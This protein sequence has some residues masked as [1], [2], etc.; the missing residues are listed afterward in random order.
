MKCPKCN[1]LGFETGDRCRNCGYDFSL[2]ADPGQERIESDLDL[3]DAGV[4]GTSDWLAQVDMAAPE[5]PAPASPPPAT[6]EPPLVTTAVPADVEKLPLFT[7]TLDT[8]EDDE[9]LIKVPPAPRPPLAVRRTPDTPRLRTA[10]TPIRRSE[11][12]AAPELPLT[13]P[14]EPLPAARRRAS[15]VWREPVRSTAEPIVGETGSPG[16]RAAAAALDILLLGGIDLA[17]VYFTLRMAGLPMQEWT[18]LPPVPLTAFLLLIKFSY[19]YAFTAVGGQTIGKMAA[20]IRVVSAD[21]RPLDAASALRRT[22]AGVVS[23]VL[24]G[25]GFLP[26]LVTSDRRALHD[27]M[28]RTRVITVPSA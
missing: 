26:A 25:L 24:L 3:R 17:V 2:M 7:P 6:P 10:A 21:E 1:Y 18:A 12:E 8:G 20:H 23:A 15:R 19:F 22:L 13:P 5:R 27:R 11:P 9:P 4:T 16:A 28:A 14:V